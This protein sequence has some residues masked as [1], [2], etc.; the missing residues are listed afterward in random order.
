[1]SRLTYGEVGSVVHPRSEVMRGAACARVKTGAA[2]TSSRDAHGSRSTRSNVGGWSAVDRQ[3]QSARSCSAR[4]AK[5]NLNCCVLTSAPRM[6]NSRSSA[7]TNSSCIYLHGRDWAEPARASGCS[8][9]PST[10]EKATSSTTTTAAAQ[11]KER[12]PPTKRVSR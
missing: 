2:D 1:M 12:A 7:A 3:H 8:A 5:S 10:R 9:D 6:M 4:R 11:A